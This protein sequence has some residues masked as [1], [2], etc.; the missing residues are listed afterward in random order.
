[1]Y[2]F[3]TIILV[4]SVALTPPDCQERTA[5]DVITGPNAP[6]SMTCMFQAQAYAAHVSRTLKV[7]TWR[8]HKIKC[9]R[10]KVS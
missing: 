2:T 10:E 1:M 6:T 5:I 8:Y 9:R 4:C 7:P 3:K